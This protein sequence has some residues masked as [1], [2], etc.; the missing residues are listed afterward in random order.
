MIPNNICGFIKY[1]NTIRILHIKTLVSR[2]LN[3]FTFYHSVAVLRM[4]VA[5]ETVT[6]NCNVNIVKI[7][8]Q[9]LYFEWLKHIL[10]FV[11]LVRCK[12]KLF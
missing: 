11:K 3:F 6:T 9:F 12:S 8:R 1:S 10:L 7:N 2:S 5:N 4:A